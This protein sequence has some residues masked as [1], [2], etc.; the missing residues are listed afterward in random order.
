MNVIIR[1]TDEF[2][3]LKP[4]I[5]GTSDDDVLRITKNAIAKI[6]EN[7]DKVNAP[8][9]FYIRIGIRGGGPEST[10]FFIEYDYYILENDTVIDLPSFQLVI[11]NRSLFY[12]L[13]FVIDYKNVQNKEGFVLSYWKEELKS[14]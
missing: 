9:S 8:K 7:I 14:S 5:V 4:E 2:F 1:E 13:K 12:L 11:D 3:I 10:N 6:E